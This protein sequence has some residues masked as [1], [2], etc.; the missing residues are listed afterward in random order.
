MVFYLNSA[1][2]NTFVF[3]VNLSFQMTSRPTNRPPIPHHCP[4]RPKRAILPN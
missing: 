4:A 3:I 2:V 1:F